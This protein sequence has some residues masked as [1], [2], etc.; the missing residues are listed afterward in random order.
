MYPRLRQ[1]LEHA[2]AVRRGHE[3]VDPR[4]EVLEVRLEGRADA[5]RGKHVGRARRVL[6]RL[7]DRLH[8]AVVP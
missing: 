6:E 7:D 5:V 4:V 8:V 2:R 1:R 3:A